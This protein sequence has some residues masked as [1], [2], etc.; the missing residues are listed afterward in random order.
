[1]SPDIPR[2]RPPAPALRSKT[3]GSPPANQLRILSPGATRS[4]RR[5][6]STT[7]GCVGDQRG[8]RAP[9]L[10]RGRRDSRP[11][12]RNST[13]RKARTGKREQGRGVF[14]IGFC[15]GEE[16]FHCTGATATP[17]FLFSGLL[18]LCQRRQQAR[19]GMSGGN[20]RCPDHSPSICARSAA[21]GCETLLSR[22]GG[23]TACC[24]WP[25]PRESRF[26]ACTAPFFEAPG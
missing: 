19:A 14:R 3:C 12:P 20:P 16:R 24:G 2:G 6:R 9:V 21:S 26:A 23:E 1:L 25:L 13:Y 5:S 11:R 22:F 18:A 7:G 15:Q 10:V 8:Q 17:V 4:R